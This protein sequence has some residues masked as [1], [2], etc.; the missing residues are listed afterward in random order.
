MTNRKVGI[1]DKTIVVLKEIYGEGFNYK[2]AKIKELIKLLYALG[3]DYIEIT[4]ELY[5]E[6]SPL[7]KD[8]KFIVCSNSFIEMKNSNDIYEILK[9]LNVNKGR[10]LRISGLEDLMF[11]DYEEIFSAI[12]NAFGENIEMCIKNKYNSATAMSLEWIRNGGRKVVTTFA[13]IGGYAPLE[14]V[15]GALTF[16]EKMQV[17]GNQKLIPKVSDIFEE[18]VENKLRSNAP[19]IG[20]DIFNVESGIHVNG[21][22]KNP[23]TYEPYDPSEIGRKRKIVIG[24]HSGTSSLE[25]K[26]KELNIEYNSNNLKI[27]LEDVRKLSTQKHRGLNNEEIKEIYEKR[28]I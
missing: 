12:R 24:K 10:Y 4:P 15:L 11:Y 27:M 5:S 13:G 23:S 7:P 14:E 21:I 8:V 2:I 9:N 22:V 18:I 16:L 26:L 17:S 1:I 20:K 3:S 25:I 19:F 28:C 6:L